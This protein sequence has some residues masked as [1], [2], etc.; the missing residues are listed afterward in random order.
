MW[1]TLAMELQIP[2]DSLNKPR[3]MIYYIRM[4]MFL[5]LL[6][7]IVC[8]FI[9]PFAYS[10]DYG[11]TKA[12]VIAEHGEP[13][14]RRFMAEGRELW[15][16]PRG[17]ITLMNGHV[18]KIVM[19]GQPS[20][21]IPSVLVNDDSKPATPAPLVPTVSAE[22]LKLAKELRSSVDFLVSPP[23]RQMEILR[24]FQTRYPGVDVTDLVRSVERVQV[25]RQNNQRNPA[26]GQPVQGEREMAQLR[27]RAEAAEREA[28]TAQAR[29]ASERQ[30]LDAEIQRRRDAERE[31]DRRARDRRTV[32]SPYNN[33]G[34]SP[35]SGYNTGYSYNTGRSIYRQ[36][37]SVIYTPSRYTPYT[38]S[39]T[40]QTTPA[41]NRPT[42]FVP[43]RTINTGPLTRR[44]SCLGSLA[45]GGGSR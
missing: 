16:Y 32:I 31:A 45:F 36:T 33:Y 35:Y 4:K 28:A 21:P 23:E 8:L 19:A 40:F 12:Q 5:F 15:Q 11:N 38:P 18:I 6:L 22:G 20:P 43:Y 39:Y 44:S 14:N 1:Q 27:Q 41:C 13:L 37:P 2:K 25:Q 34:Y 29:V 30:R 42:G 7:A 26:A 3:E 9:C 24:S 17:Q 10:A